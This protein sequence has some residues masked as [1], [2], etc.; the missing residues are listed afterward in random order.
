MEGNPYNLRLVAS[1]AGSDSEQGARSGRDQSS[2]PTNGSE[3]EQ[4]APPY[5]KSA[6]WSPDGTSILTSTADNVLR[7]YILY[8]NPLPPTGRPSNPSTPADQDRKSRP[9]DLL[10]PST[11]PFHLTPYSTQPNPEPVYATTFHPS[12]TLQDPSTTL[13]LASLRALPIRLYSPFL[14]PAI[15][16][17][18]PLV[19]P[20]TEAFTAPHSLLF[21]P[22]DPNTFFAG[23]ANLIAVFDLHRSGGHGGGPVERMRT[24]GRRSRLAG[25]GVGDIKGI[26]SALGM[27]RE[28]Y[29]AA[30]TFGRWVGLYDGRGRGGSVGAFELPP[31][32][33]AEG[34]GITQVVWSGDGRYLCVAE[35][36]SDGV[37]VWDIRG[38]GK[39]LA[40]LRGRRAHT[41]QRL[42]VE[43]VGGEVWAGGT[44]GMVRLW[45]G[46]LGVKEGVLDPAWEF[47]AHDER[48]DTEKG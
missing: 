10:S 29:L 9:P 37:S 39:Q 25:G 4:P 44:D 34:T 27:S 7:T 47:K 22:H 19:S 42:G 17:S 18:Y 35:R 43:V 31:G 45:E 23:A 30:G 1:S 32:A 5:F 46:G 28:G 15:V 41:N 26:V 33:E 38:T 8:P 24:G 13:H 2:I 12:Y 6:Q 20:T 48:W 14:S 21:S 16:A 36:C 11:C 3:G 40:W